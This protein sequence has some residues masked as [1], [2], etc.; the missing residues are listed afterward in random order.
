MCTIACSSMSVLSQSSS[1]FFLAIIIACQCF[2]FVLTAPDGAKVLNFPGFDGEL[3]SKHYAGYITLGNEGNRRHM[4][5]YFATSERNPSKDPIVF[6]TH[7]GPGCSGMNAIV[8]FH[9]KLY[10][11]LRISCQG[12]YWNSIHPDCLRNMEA[13]K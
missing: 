4:Y 11:D 1:F 8:Y 7:G 5:Y 6:W 10:E 13:F 3:P 9:D 2:Y 12:N